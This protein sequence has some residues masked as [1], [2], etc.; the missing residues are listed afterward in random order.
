MLGNNVPAALDVVKQAAVR[1]AKRNVEIDTSPV[2]TTDNTLIVAQKKGDNELSNKYEQNANNI[3]PSHVSAK[4]GDVGEITYKFSRALS[5]KINLQTAQKNQ[6]KIKLGKKASHFNAVSDSNQALII[7]TQD[8]ITTPVTL[9]EAITADINNQVQ[10]RTGA[11]S[12]TETNQSDNVSDILHVSSSFVQPN[13]TNFANV[14]PAKSDEADPVKTGKNV[15]VKSGQVVSVTSQ[16]ENKPGQITTEQNQITPKSVL[17]NTSVGEFAADTEQPQGKT[18]LAVNG[19]GNQDTG[20]ELITEEVTTGD[21]TATTGEKPPVMNVP[22]VPDGPKKPLLNDKLSQ[23]DQKVVHFKTNS[24]ET[25]SKPSN[26]VGEKPNSSDTEVLQQG[27]AFSQFSA[28]DDKELQHAQINLSSHAALKD[29]KPAHEQISGT[30]AKGSGNTTSDNNS[31]SDA[32]QFNWMISSDNLQP[33]NTEQSSFS[34]ME[35]NTTDYL[36]NSVGEQIRESVRASL[37]QGQQQITIRLN[38]PELGKVFI[39][40]QQQDDGITGIVEVSRQQ[41]RY[42]VEQA[43]PEV[44]RNLADSGIGITKIEVVTTNTE[45]FQQQPGK[46]QSLSSGQNSW[47]SQNSSADSNAQPKNSHADETNQ[48]FPNT[49]ENTEFTES[50]PMLVTDE[51][52]NMLV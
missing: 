40:F 51:S 20:S 46:D 35:A 19:Y 48:W 33:P 36:S 30:Q 25:G 22:V 42:E 45:N 16:T 3:K 32:S 13:K 47:F 52:I 44:I 39:K 1:N 8:P 18:I 38:P 7:S 5:E 10:Q 12:Y 4:K 17:T 9:T 29:S 41:T 50:Q 49:Y 11:E 15:S 43:L 23:T 2:T 27:Q 21:A 34:N 31:D 6:N 28:G 14:I 24:N 26:A 37:S